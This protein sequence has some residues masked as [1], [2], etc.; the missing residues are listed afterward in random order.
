MNRNLVSAFNINNIDIYSYPKVLDSDKNKAIYIIMSFIINSD[1]LLRLAGSSNQ[2]INA[3][4][5]NLEFCYNLKIPYTNKIRRYYI[6]DIFK[7]LSIPI[8]CGKYTCNNKNINYDF[9]DKFYELYY[10]N[11]FFYLRLYEA[12][13]LATTSYNSLKTSSYIFNIPADFSKLNINRVFF[14]NEELI[15][16]YVSASLQRNSLKIELPLPD[17]LN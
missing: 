12:I 2:A 15:R 1:F 10:K 14:S 13:R 3:F 4:N 16:I 9:M 5:N 6:N 7:V 17:L 11:R 8:G